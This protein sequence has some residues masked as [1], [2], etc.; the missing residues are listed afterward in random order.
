MSDILTVECAPISQS[1]T[2]IVVKPSD[3]LSGTTIKVSNI[4]FSLPELLKEALVLAI[5]FQVEEKALSFLL[6]AIDFISTIYGKAKRYLS[7]SECKVLLSLKKITEKTKLPIKEEML[8]Q[9][10]VD[11]YPNTSDEEF[12][13]AV[14]KLLHL[15]CIEIIDGNIILKE[16]VRV[17]YDF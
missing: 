12:S 17:K 11:D 14:S 3:S 7:E 15:D 4:K 6:I 8:K 10:T 2:G 1:I 5:H 9:Q 13:K 16:I